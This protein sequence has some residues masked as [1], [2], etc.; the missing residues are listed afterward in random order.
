MSTGNGC[1]KAEGASADEEKRWRR[2][3][4][5]PSMKKK[6]NQGREWLM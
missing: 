3:S 1:A 6:L 5:K 4:R 2:R